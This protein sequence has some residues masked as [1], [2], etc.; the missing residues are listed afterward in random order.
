MRRHQRDAM[1]EPTMRDRHANGGRRRETRRDARDDFDLDARVAQRDYLFA[2]AAEDERVAALEPHDEVSCARLPDHELLDERLGRRRASSALADGDHAR[3]GTDE[4][5]N[6]VGDEIVVQHDICPRERADRLQRQQVGIARVLRPRA[7]RG[8]SSCGLPDRTRDDLPH[9]RHARSASGAAAQR[10]LH[11]GERVHG[12]EPARARGDRRFRHAMAAA[13]DARARGH[14]KRRC[15]ARHHQRRAER[16]DV[17]PC[18]EPFA[19]PGFAG[20]VA[21]KPHRDELAVD[22]AKATAH[23]SPAIVVTKGVGRVQTEDRIDRGDHVKRHGHGIRGA[24]HDAGMCTILQDR[25][26]EVESA[27]VIAQRVAHRNEIFAARKR[28]EPPGQLRLHDAHGGVLELGLPRHGAIGLRSD[29]IHARAVASA[30]RSVAPVHRKKGSA[31]SSRVADRDGHDDAAATRFD[32]HEIALGEAAASRI[33]G[34]KLDRRLA[35]VREQRGHRAGARHRVP[36]V[37]QAC[38]ARYSLL[39]K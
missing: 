19:E 38:L 16:A 37:A 17:D 6:R 11:A 3:G 30:E 29:R 27:R 9:F 33:G 10:V 7:Q 18:R 31:G 24:Q 36:L 25:D 23:A 13:H 1:R 4:I 26:R 28:S 21:R 20:R 14:R 5:E 15:R 12:L 8:P 32:A 22:Q 2:P 34:V 35:C 39:E